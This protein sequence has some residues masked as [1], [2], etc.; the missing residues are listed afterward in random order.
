MSSKETDVQLSS[1]WLLLRNVL[2][3]ANTTERTD[4]HDFFCDP[5]CAFLNFIRDQMGKKWFFFCQPVICCSICPQNTSL[6]SVN[7]TIASNSMRLNPHIRYYLTV[8]IISMGATLLLKTIRGLVFV[9]V[10]P[11]LS[12]VCPL[13]HWWTLKLSKMCTL[14]PDSAPAWMS[15]LSFV[16]A[17]M[18]PVL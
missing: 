3:M 12:H 9:K 2:G 18:D 8:Y 11:F 15:T 16:H 4:F 5:K 13:N 6:I 14:Y 10:S 7:E 1:W 17:L